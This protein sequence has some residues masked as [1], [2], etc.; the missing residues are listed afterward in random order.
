[1]LMANVDSKFATPIHFPNFG[2]CGT[3]LTLS[4]QKQNHQELG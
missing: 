3:V 1:M 4:Y 2:V